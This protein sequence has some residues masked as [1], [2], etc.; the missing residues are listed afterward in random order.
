MADQVL[1]APPGLTRPDLFAQDNIRPA[2]PP[3]PR[4]AN[5]LIVG[6]PAYFTPEGYQAPYQP[7]QS[8]MPTNV[9]PDPIRDQFN[10]MYPTP[11]PPPP[12][13]VPAPTPAPISDPEPIIDPVVEPVV[14]PVIDPVIPPGGF[15]PYIPGVTPFP[16]I[17]GIPDYDFSGLPDFM[18]DIDFSGIPGYSGVP[19]PEFTPPPTT[20]EPNAF[21]PDIDPRDFEDFESGPLTESLGGPMEYGAARRRAIKTGT[22]MPN[23]EDYDMSPL[24]PKGPMP[25]TTTPGRQFDP[26]G[27]YDYPNPF[28]IDIDIP[29]STT[30]G[31]LTG[32]FGN[33]ENFTP[34]PMGPYGGPYGM[35]GPTGSGMDD[36]LPYESEPM[37]TPGSEISQTPIYTPPPPIYTPPPKRIEDIMPDYDYG[38]PNLRNMRGFDPRR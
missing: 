27:Q 9:A 23:I 1:V 3:T 6:G 4:Q 17:G 5:S 10:R 38:N 20:P 37:P 19:E 18:G 15:P 35:G 24:G 32:T 12:P 21:F 14:D 28:G 36:G 22:K 16:G 34:P 30:T 11:P 33:F 29:P 8:F 26:V 25:P 13:P 2:S 31:P 7:E